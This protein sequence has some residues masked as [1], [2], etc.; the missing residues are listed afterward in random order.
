MEDA[1][2][3]I[4]AQRGFFGIL[5]LKTGENTDQP[6]RMFAKTGISGH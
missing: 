5:N 3:T 2:G 6:G 4:D 1:N